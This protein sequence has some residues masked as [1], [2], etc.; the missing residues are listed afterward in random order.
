MGCEGVR[1]LVSYC[2]MRWA[3]RVYCE[4]TLIVYTDCVSV[5]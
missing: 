3:V 5:Y 4:V 2:C 1:G